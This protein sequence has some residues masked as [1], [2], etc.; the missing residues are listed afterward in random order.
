[1][2]NFLD[3]YVLVGYL[4]N[5]NITEDDVVKYFSSHGEIQDVKTVSTLEGTCIKLTFKNPE[6][7]SYCLFLL[8]SKDIT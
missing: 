7:I 4:R 1:M 6:V 3:K 2:A 5:P 8:I